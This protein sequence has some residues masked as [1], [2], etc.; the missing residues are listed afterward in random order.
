MSQA[1]NPVADRAARSGAR[2]DRAVDRSSRSETGLVTGRAPDGFV[3]LLDVARMAPV[4][5]PVGDRAARCQGRSDR[6]CDRPGSEKLADFSSNW[7]GLPLPF[8]PLL[9]HHTSLAN[10]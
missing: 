6:I 9:H 8:V 5:G 10:T 2:S 4:Q 3:S 1:Q 7:G